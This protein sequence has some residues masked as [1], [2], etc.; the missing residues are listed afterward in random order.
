MVV[1]VPP[2]RVTD[3]GVHLDG[4]D[5]YRSRVGTAIWC[6]YPGEHQTQGNPTR[7]LSAA[8]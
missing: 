5:A 4:L 3:D 2:R 8:S 6:P 1:A 7:V